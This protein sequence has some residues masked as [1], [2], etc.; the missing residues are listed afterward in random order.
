MKG[1]L[2]DQLFARGF[3]TI[4]TF[5]EIPPD[6]RHGTRYRFECPIIVSL[7]ANLNTE[8]NGMQ[9]LSDCHDLRIGGLLFKGLSH[10]VFFGMQAR[11]G[12]R[13]EDIPAE[14]LQYPVLLISDISA[15]TLQL[16]PFIS[17]N[18]H[19]ED[20]EIICGLDP[21]TDDYAVIVKS[22]T[23]TMFGAS[24]TTDISISGASSQLRFQSTV[25]VYQHYQFVLEG[26]AS[27]NNIWNEMSYNIT[28]TAVIDNGTR[29]IGS[30][31]DTAVRQKLEQIAQAAHNRLEA[32][33]SSY[34]RVQEV[35][36]T[37]QDKKTEQS[38]MV[39]E[40]QREL[41][42][43]NMNISILESD[44]SNIAVSLKALGDSVTALSAMLD[45]QCNISICSESCTSGFVNST[46]TDIVLQDVEGMCLR[47]DVIN[48]TRWVHVGSSEETDCEDWA[49]VRELRTNCNCGGFENFADCVCGVD[50]TEGPQ[51]VPVLCRIEYYATVTS[52]R[53]ENVWRPCVVRRIEVE[54]TRPCSV[55][56]DCANLIPDEMCVEDN[57]N[58]IEERNRILETVHETEM[59]AVS[60]LMNLQNSNRQLAS[61]KVKRRQLVV[62]LDTTQMAE[63][64]LESECSQL[65]N[66]ISAQNLRR[67]EESN[68]IGIAL[69]HIL[70]SHPGNNL[71]RVVEVSFSAI[72]EKESPSAVPMKVKVELPINSLSITVT[73][74]FENIDRSLNQLATLVS[75]EVIKELT[76][77]SSRRKRQSDI[78]IKT[79]SQEVI[80]QQQCA[81]LQN[82]VTFYGKLTNSIKNLREAASNL[83]QLSE[84]LAIQSFGYVH[85]ESGVYA[86]V[87]ENITDDPEVRALHQLKLSLGA[88][89]LETATV[90]TANLFILW[91]A[92]LNIFINASGEVFGYECW[93]MADCFASSV[94]VLESILNSAPQQIV[95]KMQNATRLMG[96]HLQ[97]ISDSINMTLEDVEEHLRS[98]VDIIQSIED[99]GYWCTTPPILN[100]SYSTQSNISVQEHSSLI[101][102]CSATDNYND[103]FI[104]Y[105]WK[106]NG[107]ELPMQQQPVLAI[108]NVT[109]DDAGNYTCE[110]F[111][112]AGKVET[113]W[114]FVTVLIVPVFYLEPVNQT[115]LV[116][117]INPAKMKCNATSSPN[118]QFRWHFKPPLSN[119]FTVIENQAGNEYHIAEPQQTNEGWYRCEAWIDAGNGSDLSIFSQPAYLA[120][121]NYSISVLSIPIDVTLIPCTGTTITQYDVKSTVDE[122]IMNITSLEDNDT[123]PSLFS[124]GFSAPPDASSITMNLHIMARNASMRIGSG[125]NHFVDITESIS[126]CRRA[127]FRAVTMLKSTLATA[128]LYK[129]QMVC[130]TRDVS[131]YYFLFL[132]PPGQD[133]QENFIFCRKFTTSTILHRHCNCP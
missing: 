128:S 98:V 84:D 72:V 87:G 38:D 80:L 68:K 10:K 26:Q 9:L 116:G 62:T 27:C 110:A 16:G 106:R 44:I 122:A 69:G 82:L 8:I 34:E 1:Q 48:V 19:S 103:S 46:C 45:T 21:S 120:V 99:L 129:G 107:L 67:I 59:E 20:P 31:I 132:C 71:F 74:D 89:A 90:T 112:H 77:A 28:G 75:E 127:L 73:F 100:N 2:V 133:L 101:L 60:A 5:M 51:C 50:V 108:Y 91:Q 35:S 125:I 23:I 95:V 102:D 32:A 121:V 25:S 65:N 126:V 93:T 11:D 12:C 37:L 47:P 4:T 63:M 115:R 30:D 92:E 64:N 124:L 52:Q 57:A 36:D 56:S 81:D 76:G 111:N 117:D 61:M 94:E 86:G 105:K 24:F 29:S 7:F 43:T 96:R 131:P 54:Q 55:M 15:E 17:V 70:N 40:L 14:I 18:A 78:L 3:S 104:K 109:E 22:A 6:L 130:N 79:P 83:I 53:V 123:R 118:P 41:Q 66:S 113:P 85:N 39:A 119:N 114:T 88:Q 49:T 42:L 13:D 33:R 97:S 58:C